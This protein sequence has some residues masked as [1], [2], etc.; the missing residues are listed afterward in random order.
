MI[1]KLYKVDSNDF[2]NRTGMNNASIQLS[3]FSQLQ[4]DFFLENRFVLTQKLL[5]N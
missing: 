3:V 1:L 5:S 2:F 4:Y